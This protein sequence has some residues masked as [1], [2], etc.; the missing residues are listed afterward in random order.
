MKPEPEIFTL[1]CERTEVVPDEVIF[2]GDGGFDEL[3]GAA[4][5][6]MVPIHATW[7]RDREVDWNVEGELRRVGR[8]EELGSTLD[9][10]KRGR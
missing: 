6:G 8:I 9:E 2:V 4:A 3:A 7:Y 10:M 1:A 5:V